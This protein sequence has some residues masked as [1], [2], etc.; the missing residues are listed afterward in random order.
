MIESDVFADRTV[1]VFGL[2]RSG[3]ASARALMAGGSAVQAWDDDARAR[4]AATRRGIPL[5]NLYRSDLHPMAALVLS[6]GV[7]FRHPSPHPVVARANEAG[8]EVLGDVELFARG[9]PQ[10]SVVGVTGTNGKSTT[11]ALIGHILATLGRS[12]AVGGNLG[13]PVLDL[14]VLDEDGVYVLELSS[15]QLDTTRTLVCDVAVLLNIGADHLD[16]HGG[17]SGYVAAKKRIFRGQRRRHAAVIGIDDAGGAALHDQLGQ[18]A[19]QRLIPVAVGREVE[20]GVAVID[21]VLRD[22][23]G[24]KPVTADLAGLRGLRGAHNW[25][26][27]AAAVAAARALGLPGAPVVAALAGFPG[28]PHRLEEVAV[29]EGVRYV[30]DSKATN[31]EAAAR[32]L[33]TFDNIYWIAGGRA[34]E[35]GIAALAPLFSRLAHAFLIG[36]AGPDFAATLAGR[37]ALTESRDLES[38][39]AQAHALARKEA[40]ADPVVLLSPA[41]A[42]FDQWRDFAARGDRFRALVHALPGRRESPR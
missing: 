6:P 8:C 7:P 16:R 5:G 1:A 9:K 38:A 41:C 4:R 42:S 13:Q 40:R 24:A 17:L 29:I 35:G 34:K 37:V 28:L 21:G 20:G 36:E 39:L 2:G 14:P 30:N 19:R 23:T 11:T 22:A 25:Q 18:A 27:A 26:N 31:A 15:Y 3:L 12:A 10:A 33:A 32:A